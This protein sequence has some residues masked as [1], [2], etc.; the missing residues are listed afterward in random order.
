MVRQVS[1]GDFGVVR[2]DEELP[3]LEDI[4]ERALAEFEN[5]PMAIVLVSG[6]ELH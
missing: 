2:L 3:H 6:V 4:G 5:V 1:L